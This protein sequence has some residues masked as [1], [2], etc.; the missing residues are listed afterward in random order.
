M[1]RAGPANPVGR[2][3]KVKVLPPACPVETLNTP[4]Q[5]NDAAAPPE[6]AEII[7]RYELVRRVDRRTSEITWRKLARRDRYFTFTF[8]LLTAQSSLDL[9]VVPDPY[10]KET[11][12]GRRA[13]GGG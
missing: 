8:E 4:E 3:P 2:P 10:R 11:E 12:K 7:S 13:T 5:D 1:G 6:P 9:A